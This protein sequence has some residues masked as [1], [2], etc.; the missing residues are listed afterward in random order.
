MD[1]K[2]DCLETLDAT[3]ADALKEQAT[4]Y[5]LGLI[6]N[7]TPNPGSNLT[8]GSLSRVCYDIGT[9][10]ADDFPKECNK[11]FNGSASVYGSRESQLSKCEKV[12]LDIRR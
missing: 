3:C 10:I 8:Q 11:F 5:T 9:M 12:S 2:G 7:P 4:A 6:G 1:D